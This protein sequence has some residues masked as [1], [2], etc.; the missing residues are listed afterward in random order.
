[1]TEEDKQRLQMQGV[2]PDCIKDELTIVKARYNLDKECTVVG[3]K[4]EQLQSR[5]KVMES[6][7]HLLN[8]SQSDGGKMHNYYY[9]ANYIYLVLY[10]YTAV[11]YYIGAGRRNTGDWCFKDGFITF[12]DIADLYLRHFKGR[13]L[14]IIS[15]CSYSGRWVRECMEFLDELGVQPCGHKAREKGILIKVYTSCRS[16]EVPTEYRYSVSGADNDKNTGMLSYYL[17]KQLLKRQ[18]TD[19]IDTSDL[20]CNSKTI[21]KPCTL[22]PRY[23]WKKWRESERVQLVRGKDQ[24]EP[25]WYYV[26]LKDD[27]N[28][29][30]EFHEKLKSGN[31]N[32]AKYG[33]VLTSG[34]G[35]DPPKCII[36]RISEEYDP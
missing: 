11:I 16:T 9:P 22:R 6:I 12:R 23:T 35:R 31:V 33:R 20:L 29:V 32:I 13:V 34:L 26:L 15:D 14:T 21:D 7:A 3:V 28:A 36:N 25:V 4:S 30:R 8:S 10:V 17:Q 19:G 24:G 5:A 18:T 2:S 1:M 27:E